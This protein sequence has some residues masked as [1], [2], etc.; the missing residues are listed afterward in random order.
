M[1]ARW[2]WKWWWVALLATRLVWVH[3]EESRGRERSALRQRRRS[4]GHGKRSNET[5]AA[6]G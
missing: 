1:P 4:E 3:L 5:G 2:W 6:G